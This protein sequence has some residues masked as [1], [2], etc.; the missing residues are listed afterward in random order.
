MGSTIL[1]HEPASSGPTVKPRAEM[2]PASAHVAGFDVSHW[3]RSVDW[4]GAW[5]AGARFVYMKATEG[6]TFLDSSFGTFYT[7]SYN[8]G[9][10]RGAYHFALPD[11]SSGATQANY[12]LAHGGRWS[13]DGRTLPPVLDIEY[14][15][16]GDTCYGLSPSQMVG[17]ITDFVGTIRNAIGRAP[18][19]YTTTRW[20]TTCTGN[21]PSLA[22][23]SPLWLAR[24]S[25][26]PGTLPAGWGDYTFWQY[27][28]SGTYPGD[29]DTFNGS[30]DQL[31][32]FTY[33]DLDPIV[34]HYDALGGAS[35]YLGA[36]VGGQYPIAGGRAQNYQGGIIYYSSLTG[37]WAV[38]GAI[39]GKYQQLG[40]PGGFLGFPVT[41]EVGTP[42]GVGR[43]NHFSTSASI[44]W[45]QAAGAWSVHGLIRARWA[46]LGWERG[47]MGY[48]V[49]DETGT[50]DGV[51][52]FNHFSY[53]ASI[54]WTPGTG[55]WSV[56]GVIRDRWAALGW[57]RGRLGYPV[58]DEFAINGGRRSNFQGGYITYAS[59]TGAT[60]V[61]YY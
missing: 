31:A 30:P 52:R 33:R 49:T 26:A 12:F 50:P 61:V 23:A 44:Y 15:P 17:W 57:E 5:N 29:Q 20:W 43:F 34:L 59:A 42:D 32:N 51:G 54:Y 4:Q 56:H 8:A 40:G 14:N 7:D 2:Q 9:Y 28:D 60:E 41:D 10:S 38:H 48:P 46:A 58:S 13:P 21:A 25:T 22:A 37:A 47:P 19:I 1:A 39:L 45:T 6:T 18:V 24:Y 16:Y 3:Q 11:V 35:S 55:A 36:P 53:G 27:A